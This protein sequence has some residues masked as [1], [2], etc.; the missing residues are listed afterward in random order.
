ML[1]YAGGI[2]ATMTDDFS[3]LDVSKL[4]KKLVEA[5]VVLHEKDLGL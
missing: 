2:A 1:L 4:R 5:G 3:A